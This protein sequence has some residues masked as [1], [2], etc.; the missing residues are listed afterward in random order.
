MA[1]ADIPLSN[2]PVQFNNLPAQLTSL[3]GREQQVKAVCA[4]LRRKDVRL[5]TLT[6]MGGI[7]KTRLG[8]QV[9]S[10]LLDVFPDGVCF[11]PLAPI[12]NPLQVIPA[13]AHLL[14]LDHQHTTQN[15][16]AEDL[17]YLR[18]FLREKTFLLLLDNFEQVVS[19]APQLIELL[20]ACPKVSILVTSRAVL[21]VQGEQEFPVPA[22]SLPTQTHLLTYENLTQFAAVDLFVQRAQAVKPDFLFTEANARA[23]A[24]ICIRLDGLPLAIELAAARIKL[25]PP[26][27]LLQR[28]SHILPMLTGEI[29]NV[30]VRQQ[31]LRNTIAWSYNLLNAA[32]Q[33]LFQRLSVFVGSY[34][35]DAVEAVCGVFADG[36]AH[37]LDGVASLIDKSLLQQTEQEGEQ[38]SLVML[39]TI[40]EYGLEALAHS[41][42]EE[43]TRQ[44][45]ATYYLMLAEKAEPEFGGAEQAKWLARLEREHDNL[46]AALS[47]S[48][49]QG[50]ARRRMEMALRLGGALRRFW[51]VHG[52]IGEGRAFLEQALSEHGEVS[53]PT[54][55]KALMTAANLA[56]T[57]NDYDRTQ[58]LCQESL[59]LF[60]ELGN[61]PGVAF[62]LHLLGAV[63]WT[64]GDAATGH[65][66]LEQALAIFREID[67]KDNI[68]WSLYLLGLF[69]GIR[70]EYTRA[71]S[72]FEES[73][74]LHRQMWHK[75]GIAFSLIHMAQLLFVS[76]KDQPTA[77]TLLEEGFTLA[78]ELGD[79]DSTAYSYALKGQI[80]LSQGDIDNARSFLERGVNLYR[81]VGSLHG[82]GESLSQLARV[83]AAQG[84][85]SSTF[86]LY[87][88]SLAIAR[89]LRH[90]GLIASCLEG[91]AQGMVGQGKVAWA[92]RLWGAA[93]ALRESVSIPRPP[94]EQ[95]AY[96]RSVSSA[97]QQMSEGAFAAAWLQ[98]RGMT[99]EQAL[100]EQEQAITSSLAAVESAP[101]S[102]PRLAHIAGLTTREVEVLRL[103]ARGLTN[104][105]I[106]DKLGLSEKT[107]AHH[108]TH[109]FNKTGSEN[110][111]AATAFAIRHGLA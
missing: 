84:D 24:D 45:H 93:Q 86:A 91:L 10:E 16:M 107:V 61:R 52:H 38:A 43:I 109:I 44:A 37:I 88:E 7:G 58:T 59:A 99:P 75:R 68:A 71:Y 8:I 31:T 70:G 53:K 28:L 76:Q 105:D 80:A 42:E 98:G 96:E 66:L 33:R 25:L 108:L 5:V 69:H 29:Q 82:I 6:G 23:I 77:E 110:R 47:W 87:R 17:D 35:L 79:K 14:G 65:S 12:S 41:G 90:P 54:R 63:A 50:K 36:T 39:E 100:T 40:R 64:R 15:S 49:E 19:A 30:P 20:V 78:K 21:H 51:L 103:V 89:E 94:I 72:L 57:Q 2:P 97:R 3:I 83:V 106:A 92:A 62:S 102:A 13:I 55:A 73:L 11:V 4:L 111:T 1:L 74:A 60:Q 101:V 9:A 81:E 104:T 56:V 95:A 67:S 48:L 22:L 85:T 18:A 32:E 26:Q 34:T 46:R 27:A